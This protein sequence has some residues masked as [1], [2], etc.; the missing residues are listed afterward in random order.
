MGLRIIDNG[1]LIILVTFQSSPLLVTGNSPVRAMSA[2]RET[3]RVST[4][5]KPISYIV[6]AR[7]AL[8]RGNVSRVYRTARFNRDKRTC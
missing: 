2:A 3:A 4:T 6:G 8:A 5:N 7:L 1:E